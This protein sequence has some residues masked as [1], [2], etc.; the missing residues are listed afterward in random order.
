MNYIKQ[1]QLDN[2]NSTAAI[3]LALQSLSDFRA[4][5]ASSPKFTGTD[6]D[7]ERK[8]W[9]ATTDVIRWIDTLR[10]DIIDRAPPSMF[11]P[12]PAP[13]AKPREHSDH[14]LTEKFR[15]YLHDEGVSEIKRYTWRRG[16]CYYNEEELRFDRLTSAERSAAAAVQRYATDPRN[17]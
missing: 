5:L 4:Y 3:E 11:A 13:S 17:N 10:F 1:I 8:D 6:S 7:G 16:L 14:E 15:E 9:I 12:K 2:Q